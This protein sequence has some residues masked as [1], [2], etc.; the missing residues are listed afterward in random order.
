MLTFNPRTKTLAYGD[1]HCRIE[2]W[3]LSIEA[4]SERLP[5]T[6]ARLGKHG[7]D[8][9][10][11]TLIF[12]EKGLEW[13]V[14]VEED[15]AAHTSL[16]L[17][18]TLHN[19]SCQA[20]KLG[21]ACLLVADEGMRIGA[22]P[23][24]LVGLSILKELYPRRVHRL[25]DPECPR[26]S[27]VKTQFY[28]RADRAAV[29]VGFISFLR[30]GTEVHHRYE[31]G[32]GITHLEAWC[33]FAGWELAPGASTATE[34]LLVASGTNPYAQL[35]AWADKVMR[36]H[37]PRRWED[38]PLGWVGWAWVD[39]F[40]VERYGEVV[41]R[42]AQAIR[43]R[44][45]GFGLRYIWVSIGN[46]AEGTPGR[47]LEWNEEL[48][49]GGPEELVR[50]LEEHGLK[51]GLWCAPFWLC[52]WAKEQLA[53][54]EEALLR[55]P[56]GSPLIVRP[57]WQFGKAGE[58]PRQDR[59]VI[60]A[61]DPSHPKTLAFLRHTFETYRRWGVRYYMLDFLHAA[62]GNICSFPYTQHWDKSLVAGPEAYH[63]ALQVIR[64]AAGDD[65]YFLSSTGPSVHN[66]GIMD[67]IRTGNDFGE[68]R[69]LYPD[70]YF[71]PATF[72]INSGA[73]WTGPQHALQN[74]AAAYYTHRKLY[75]NDSGNVLTVDKPLP[76][77]DAQI[78]A[79]IHALSGGPTMLGDDLD[80]MDEERLAL[81]KKTL[82]RPKEV[83]FPV[84]LFDAVHPAHPHVFQR[85]IHKPWGD[86]DVV[87][88]YN[89]GDDLLRERIALA[90]LRLD[91]AARYLVWEF[92]NSAYLGRAQRELVAIVPPRSVRVYRLVADR[93]VP[94]LLGT[95]MHLTMGE[96]EIEDCRWDAAT[97]TLS[98]Q[99]LRPAGER[100]N[101][102]IHAPETMRV[103]TPRGVWIAK[104][105]R[106]N[107][108]ILRV[109][110]EFN[111]SPAG[112]RIAFAPLAQAVDVTKLHP[113][114]IEGVKVEG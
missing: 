71:Y 95:D 62:A 89:F 55:H 8:P 20:I 82:P 58:T 77:S 69:A 103:A 65:T 31:A 28:N 21:K 111:G 87:A 42:N 70:S 17:R 76:L 3:R 109:A 7:T 96:M 18:S 15:Q 25:A 63:R 79:T 108:L 107:T 51:L 83:A 35:E 41:L 64:Q 114:G 88:V 66:V 49:P 23:R 74:Q 22:D 52:A 81:I 90:D 5:S 57:E 37:P 2:S 48:F 38:A 104:D 92:W 86:F 34:T 97:L 45:G 60:Y 14:T 44:L 73:F 13:R 105:A 93:G 46:L 78:H 110:L 50:R 12:P 72:V 61:L 67:G 80:R 29:Q 27:K 26:E 19:R 9:L 98:G 16:V 6:A 68:G 75:L 47:W 91:P 11:F 59:P 39:G 24:E 4:D 30:A 53:E 43:R 33:D 10:H 94:T 54:L 106:D 99:A 40:T 102:F 56:D 1:A 84:D 85:K 36:Q 32:R 101:V 100:G 112:W 113:D